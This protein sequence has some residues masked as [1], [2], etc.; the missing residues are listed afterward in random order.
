MVLADEILIE[1]KQL[2]LDSLRRAFPWLVRLLIQYITPV[3]CWNHSNKSL[4]HFLL[5]RYEGRHISLINV[6]EMHLI[7]E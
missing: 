5:L 3:E 2:L 4:A 1:Q 6:I 7:Y